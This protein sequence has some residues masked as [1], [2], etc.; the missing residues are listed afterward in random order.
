MKSTNAFCGMTQFYPGASVVSD[1]RIR[2]LP[3]SLI[4]SPVALRK[5]TNTKMT[6]ELVGFSMQ[7]VASYV[8]Q[9]SSAHASVQRVSDFHC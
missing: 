7:E 9:P 4:F 2:S 3:Q 5:Q 1:V 6:P 8:R